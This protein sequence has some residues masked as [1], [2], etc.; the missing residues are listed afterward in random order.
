MSV[1]ELEAAVAKLA[2]DELSRF[3]QWF[4]EF[5]AD[6]WDEQIERDALAG[7]LD[8]LGQEADDDYDAGRCTPI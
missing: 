4:Q 6:A 8:R 2:P 3:S 7:R 5:M 1:E